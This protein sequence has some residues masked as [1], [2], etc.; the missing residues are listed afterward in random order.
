VE[1]TYEWE[2]QR[3][4]LPDGQH[5]VVC[6][7]NDITERAEK[8]ARERKLRDL[9]ADRSAHL[10]TLVQQR[11]AK[12]SET[13]GELEAF[14]YSIAHD[15]RA[16]LRSLQGYAHILL[17]D[18]ARQLDEDGRHFLERIANSA[19]RM[20]KLIRDVL[21]YSQVVRADFP[22][23]RVDVEQLLCGIVDTYPMLARDKADILLAG[24]F[25]AVLGNEAMLTQ[26][27]SNL[28]GNAVKFVPTGVK[29]RLKVWAE[30]RGQTVRLLVQDNGI[31]IPADQHEKIFG[32]F[33]RANRDFD[34]TGIGLAIVKKAAARIG[35]N[36][37][38][39]SEPGRGSTFW[40]DVRKG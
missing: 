29:P 2:T 26:I 25:P 20:D 40:V 19:A 9:L 4:T 36:V 21:D 7:F 38:L 35:G 24:P 37:G 12:L 11:T 39:Q 23:E 31:G 30:S 16:P 17:T 22:L 13:I 32:I 14:S 33:Q 3:V 1:K 28:L 27:F 5:G 8:E 10:E 34:G 18:H 6:Y 15:M